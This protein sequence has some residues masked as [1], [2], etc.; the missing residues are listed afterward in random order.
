MVQK[1]IDRLCRLLSFVMVTCLALMV[2]MVFG[3]VVLRY[4]FNTGITISEELSRWLFVWMTFLGA[5]IALR[6]HAHLGTDTLVSRLPV[7]GKKI[8]LGTTHLL[9][10]WVCWLMLKGAWQQTRINLDT[11]SAV[12][13]ASMG[14]FYASGVL[15]AVLAILFILADFWRLVTGQLAE[16]EL[17]EI[18]ESE[19]VAPHAGD[20]ATAPAAKAAP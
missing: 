5:L 17:V 6:R 2:V 13:E 3:N 20:D 10:L 11:T 19:D 12:M 16:S 14:W 9:M 15:F 4:G 1:L 7:V 8:C 18:V